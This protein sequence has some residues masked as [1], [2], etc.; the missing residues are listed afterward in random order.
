MEDKGG[1]PRGKKKRHSTEKPGFSSA[2]FFPFLL[3]LP[4]P[5]PPRYLSPPKVVFFH[6]IPPLSRLSPSYKGKKTREELGPDFFVPSLPLSEKEED[7]RFFTPTFSS[8]LLDGNIKFFS[9]PKDRWLRHFFFPVKERR[10]ESRQNGFDQAHHQCRPGI[11]LPLL[12]P[13]IVKR[14]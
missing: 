9:R 8:R 1:R 3:F 10:E 6:E 5:S 13:E 12:L 7:R 14:Q 4:A 2:A 11:Q